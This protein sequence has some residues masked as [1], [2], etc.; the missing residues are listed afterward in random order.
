MCCVWPAAAIC[1]AAEKEEETWKKWN[2]GGA[3]RKGGGKSDM[4]RGRKKKDRQGA[5]ESDGL[6]SQ[7]HLSFSFPRHTFTQCSNTGFIFFFFFPPFSVS[8]CVQP[9]GYRSICVTTSSYTKLTLCVLKWMCVFVRGGGDTVHWT[10]VYICASLWSTRV[11][12]PL[13]LLLRA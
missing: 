4:K 12:L 13:L 7:T 8:L 1:A 11:C 5:H 3:R 6:F 10:V 9:S 2:G